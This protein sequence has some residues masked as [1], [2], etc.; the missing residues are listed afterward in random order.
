MIILLGAFMILG[1]R[2]GPE[3]LTDHLDVTFTIVWSLALANVFGT[4]I[5]LPL[6]GQLAKLALVRIQILAPIIISILFL[7]SFLTTRDYGDLV[8][9]IAFGVFAW[10]MKLA[11]WPR[12]PLVLGLVLGPIIG[13]YLFIS[14]H[15]YDGFGWL[16]RPGVLLIFLAMAI[17]V[18]YGLIRENQQQEAPPNT[19]EEGRADAS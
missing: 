11:G 17:S 4:L 7:A 16:L 18:A 10:V 15:A 8:T 9:L 5:L 1:L 2:P 3:M 19:V 12:P 14:T 6:T 13:K